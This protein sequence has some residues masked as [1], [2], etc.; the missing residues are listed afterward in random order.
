MADAHVAPSLAASLPSPEGR[1]Y[2]TADAMVRTCRERWLDMRPDEMQRGFEMAQRALAGDATDGGADVS[3][4]KREYAE[5]FGPA[6]AIS[7]E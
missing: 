1:N 7:S 5:P 6:A 2:S 3:R 4:L